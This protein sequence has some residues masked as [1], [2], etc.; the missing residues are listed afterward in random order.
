M[1]FY[2]GLIFVSNI[3]LKC[4]IKKL[5]NLQGTNDN[6]SLKLFSAKLNTVPGDGQMSAV[7]S[8]LGVCRRFFCLE[9]FLGIRQFFC[10]DEVDDTDIY[11]ST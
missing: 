8:G 2:I 9:H 5:T 11:R 1:I 7:F 10:L 3:T 4:S 6:Y